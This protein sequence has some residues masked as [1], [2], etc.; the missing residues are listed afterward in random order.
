MI[1]GLGFVLAIFGIAGTVMGIMEI[2][3][4]EMSDFNPWALSV[5]GIIFL[6]AGVS[7]LKRRPD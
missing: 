7:L 2:S 6:L 3:G 1:K 4:R 5:L